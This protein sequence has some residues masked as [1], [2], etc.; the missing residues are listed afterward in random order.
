MILKVNTQA[1]E[2]DIHIDKYMLGNAAKLWGLDKPGRRALVVSDNSVP[3][4]FE[5]GAQCAD[6][7][8]V[9]LAGNGEELK[10]FETLQEVC[11]DMLGLNLNRNDCVIAVGGGVIGDLTGFAASCYMRGIDFY[12]IP[13]TLLSQVDSSVGGKTAIDF[14]GVKNIIGSFYQPKGVLIDPLVLE[15]LDD[16]QLACGMAEVIKMAATLDPEFFERLE[17][18]AAKTLPWMDADE[19]RKA[20]DYVKAKCYARDCLRAEPY[21]DELEIESIIEKSLRAK[22]SV[23]EKDEKEGG[24]RRVLNFGHTLGHGIESNSDMLHGEA[25]ALGML[26]M[27]SKEM[28]ARL[29]P[30]Y[31]WA[32][33]PMTFDAAAAGTSVEKIIETAMHDKKAERASVVTVQLEEPGKFSFKRC[34]KEELTALYREVFV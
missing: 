5:V 9:H 15:T 2:Y 6:A 3:Y 33:L 24:L 34:T 13:T 30:M 25:V 8:V 29:L 22:I 31:K 1:G 27:A 12:N 4:A 11:G 17:E 14:K 26:P 10:D 7:C 23:V 28:R 32:G 20:A 16:R 21:S 19:K 18:E